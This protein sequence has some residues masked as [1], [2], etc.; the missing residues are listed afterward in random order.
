M[1]ASHRAALVLMANAPVVQGSSWGAAKCGGGQL[2]ARVPLALV[3]E[4]ADMIARGPGGA[5]LAFAAR[6]NVAARDGPI[7]ALHNASAAAWVAEACGA[8]YAAGI[9]EWGSEQLHEGQLP[10]EYERQFRVVYTNLMGDIAPSLPLSAA[11]TS[12]AIMASVREEA[13]SSAGAPLGRRDEAAGRDPSDVVCLAIVSAALASASA[14][15]VPVRIYGA[16]V[17]IHYDPGTSNGARRVAG[18]AWAVRARNRLLRQVSHLLGCTRQSATKFADLAIH[19]AAGGGAWAAAPEYKGTELLYP[20]GGVRVVVAPRFV[21]WGRKVESK[22]I[23]FLAATE[24]Y[25]RTGRIYLEGLSTCGTYDCFYAPE[26]DPLVSAVNKARQI[27]P[28]APR[29]AD[30]TPSVAFDVAAGRAFMEDADPFAAPVLDKDRPLSHILLMATL[31]A[32]EP[33][34]ASLP[35]QPPVDEGSSSSP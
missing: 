19:Y 34:A 35:E 30:L 10:G 32:G 28:A 33:S 2:L 12:T 16:A 26:K 24:A 7:A 6:I 25:A 29:I 4:D 15:H 21:D 27:F 18:W 14:A 11:T 5:H 17:A 31:S 23:A 3:D 1:V 9:D 20:T 22:E 8:N 13:A